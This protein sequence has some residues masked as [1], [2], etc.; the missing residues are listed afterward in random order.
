M[1]W[2][3]IR[4]WCFFPIF[5]LASLHSQ[6]QTN[7]FECATNPSKCRSGNNQSSSMP[8]PVPTSSNQPARSAVIDNIQPAISIQQGS[9]NQAI[10]LTTNP[11]DTQKKTNGNEVWASFDPSITSQDR[12]LEFSY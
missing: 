10:K 2:S 1:F 9:T 7:F 5:V 8:V 3:L 12:Q 11:I 4:S 6:A